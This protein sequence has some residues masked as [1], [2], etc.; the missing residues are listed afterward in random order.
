MSLSSISWQQR[1]IHTCCSRQTWSNLP[2]L[3]CIIWKV[4]LSPSP[5]HGDAPGLP[6]KREGPW[7]AL[8]CFWAG[9]WKKGGLRTLGVTSSY[10]G[11]PAYLESELCR[12]STQHDIQKDALLQ[13]P[14]PLER[15]AETCPWKTVRRDREPRV[16][17][18]SSS[19]VHNQ[20]YNLWQITFLFRVSVF[21]FVKGRY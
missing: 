2:A 13:L 8:L 21:P 5:R 9:R 20:L 10:Q 11:C 6:G 14:G 19:S 18:S 12:E 1:G 15:A 16:L 4:H 17:G 7:C 3:K